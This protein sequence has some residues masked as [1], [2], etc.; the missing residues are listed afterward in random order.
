VRLSYT[1]PIERE[2]S[3]E[4]NY[5]LEGGDETMK[6]Y[7]LV[8]SLALVGSFLV[9]GAAEAA[10]PSKTMQH[11]WAFRGTVT[12]VN[13]DR[14]EM[15]GTDTHGILI[16]PKFQIT[17][18]TMLENAV[19][20]FDASESLRLAIKN[21]LERGSVVTVW[22]TAGHEALVIKNMAPKSINEAY[23]PGECPHCGH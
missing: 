11:T 4:Q 9:G 16:W 17:E 12:E 5:G 7:M 14:I 10:T 21:D 2:F 3:Y 15:M 22:Y 1:L 19:L 20:L 18:N 6:R 8:A 23:G 13:R